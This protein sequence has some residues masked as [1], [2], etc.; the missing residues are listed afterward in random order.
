MTE[1]EKGQVE[2]P[3]SGE[4]ETPESKKIEDPNIGPKNTN[5]EE[6]ETL[7]VPKGVSLS[8]IIPDA[9]KTEKMFESVKDVDTLFKNY[10]HAQKRLGES[11]KIPGKDAAPEELNK[12][13]SKLG[14]PETSEGYE[15]TA[16]EL[17]EGL[18]FD[19]GMVG[20]FKKV[21]H[22]LKL[23][24]RQVQGVLDWYG[25]KLSS[26][27]NDQGEIYDQTENALREELG[28]AYERKVALAARGIKALGGQEGFDLFVASG[29]DRHPLG[30]KM[31]IK[32][33]EIMAES[34]AIPGEVD[35][36]P[37]SSAAQEELNAI[38]SNPKHPYHN[39]EAPGH[40]EAFAKVT[41]LHELIYN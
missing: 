27:I 13:Y 41:K 30:V 9:Y 14:V 6:N 37:S 19:D 20:D 8:E 38:L 1:E 15:V 18:T 12:F 33:G 35:H 10:V 7:N 31:A 26:Y 28:A 24:P 40:K 16:P 32:I 21:S 23:T 2:D 39:P 36:V 3:E 34:E 5:S 17:P 11:I 22:D 25:G 4:S 29:L